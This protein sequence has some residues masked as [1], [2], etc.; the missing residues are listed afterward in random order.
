[1]GPK[2]SLAIFGELHP[3]IIKSYGLKGTILA[4]TVFI[5]N[6]PMKNKKNATRSAL[7]TNDLQAVERDFSFVLDE[8]IEASELKIASESV[9]TK[10][11]ECVT[12]FDEFS[13]E[14]AHQQLGDG[15]KSLAV[16]V[17]LQPQEKT[18]TEK[19]IDEVSVKI[20]ENVKDKT[21]GEL[22]A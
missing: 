18:L 20:I 6:I 4:F 11:I 17:R 16:S 21:G 10:L 14:K 2:N 12:V 15:L 5:E 3:K 1:L 13:G 8:R 19:E 22:R 9:D 7:D